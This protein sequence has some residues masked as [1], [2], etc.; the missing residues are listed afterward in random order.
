MRAREGEGTQF[1]Q[2][3]P[4]I[5]SSG[6]ASSASPP[7]FG[8]RRTSPTEM[9]AKG[10]QRDA[11]AG[12]GMFHRAK[13][14][15]GRGFN[16]K[17]LCGADNFPIGLPNRSSRRQ[18]ALTFLAGI[19]SGLMSAAT[20]PWMDFRIREFPQVRIDGSGRTLPD[21]ET[22]ASLDY[23]GSEMSRRG[24]FP[25]AQIRQ[26]PDAVFTKRDAELFHRA[27]FAPRISRR[28][29]QRA[30]FHQRLVEK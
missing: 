6:G 29:N 26:F 27:N 28:T 23:K 22:S 20:R 9:N 11:V 1:C 16:T 24:G 21:K 30:K 8:R 2:R 12:D 13:R 18:L 14:E 3:Q 4:D 5:V 7:M 15:N 19:M 17:T 25:F 10:F